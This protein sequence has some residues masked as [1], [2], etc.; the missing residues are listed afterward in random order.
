MHDQTL[1]CRDCGGSF[2]FDE[3]QQRVFSERHYPDKPSRCVRCRTTRREQRPERVII[4]TVCSKCGQATQVRFVPKP[5]FAV[6]CRQCLPQAQPK[7]R[8]R[9][10]RAPIRGGRRA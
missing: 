5:G 1:I 4:D 2:V 7:V 3:S 8:I 9:P 10:Q 6:L